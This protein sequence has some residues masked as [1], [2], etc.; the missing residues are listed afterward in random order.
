[1]HQAVQARAAAVVQDVAAAQDGHA[2]QRHR[3]RQAEAEGPDERQAVRHRSTASAVSRT[4]SAD[5]DGSRPP[6]APSTTIPAATAAP[7]ARAA[8]GGR[9]CARGGGRRRPGPPAAD[10][11]PHAEPEEH[12]AGDQADGGR[13]PRRVGGAGGAEQRQPSASTLP[14]CMS[15]TVTPSTAACRTRARSP[16]R[17]PAATALPCPGASACRAPTANGDEQRDEP[18]REPRRAVDGGHEAALQRQ[19]AAER[20]LHVARAGA[21]GGAA[22]RGSTASS[23]SGEAAVSMTRACRSPR[24][25]GSGCPRRAAA[26]SAG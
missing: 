7:Q 22:A 2:D 5:G 13:Q 8:R 16:M 10:Q 25:C 14:V 18:G 3:R 20:A 24:G 12:Q 23:C 17:Y 26:R 6:A 4:S 19:G 15:A 21:G 1:V 9:G 11:Q